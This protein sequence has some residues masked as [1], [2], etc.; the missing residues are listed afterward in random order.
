MP[1]NENSMM[2]LV[3]WIGYYVS[4]FTFLIVSFLDM[5]NVAPLEN[6]QADFV[7]IFMGYVLFFGIEILRI[8][9]KE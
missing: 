4:W 1:M 6:H 3:K 7:L 5:F 9:M 2:K 8:E